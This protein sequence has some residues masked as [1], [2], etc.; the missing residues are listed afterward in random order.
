MEIQIRKATI[1]DLESIQELNHKLFDREYAKFDKTLN[2]NWTYS[3]DGAKYFKKRITKD[4]CCAFIALVDG[5]VAGYLV[6]ALAEKEPYRTISI[7]AELEDMHVLERYQR[8]GIGT[9]L[10]NEFVSWCRKKNVT[11]LMVTASIRNSQA[12]SFYKK[13][14]FK[15]YDLTLERDL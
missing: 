5:N 10:L 13:N 6:G 14:V 15:Y 1:N 4:D 2:C 9:D 7:L 12:I 3:K 11:R 8:L